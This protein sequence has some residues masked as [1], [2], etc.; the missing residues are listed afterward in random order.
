VL[1]VFW[2][3]I[4]LGGY[5]LIPAEALREAWPSEAFPDRSGPK[6]LTIPE[7]E[8]SP[9][10]LDIV[11]S[12]Y[13]GLAPPNELEALRAQFLCSACHEAIGKAVL[14]PYE[15]QDT[16][17]ETYR[18]A[19]AIVQILKDPRP[20]EYAFGRPLHLSFGVP[21]YDLEYAD[22]ELAMYWII[23]C[24]R[25]EGTPLSNPPIGPWSNN[26]HSVFEE[27]ELRAWL[28]QP[29]IQRLRHILHP[30]KALQFILRS[31]P[32]IPL[33]DTLIE[34]L[35]W[36]FQELGV[37][38]FLNLSDHILS[39]DQVISLVTRFPDIEALS[40]SWNTA[41]K[42]EDIPRIIS[43]IPSLR[44]LH[45][46]HF[47]GPGLF[48]NGNLHDLVLEH[49]ELFHQLESLFCP[50]LLLYHDDEFPFVHA[51]ISFVFAHNTRM[52]RHPPAVVSSVLSTPGQ[53]V[54]ALTDILPLAFQEYNYGESTANTMWR[55]NLDFPLR[56]RSGPNQFSG[57]PFYMTA[58]ML[59]HAAF[60]CGVRKPGEPWSERRIV[61]VP[62]HGMFNYPPHIGQVRGT[63]LFHFDWDHRRMGRPDP[64]RNCW[65]FIY[66]E[67]IRVTV[68][69]EPGSESN[70]PQSA[71]EEQQNS[72][73][74][75]RYDQRKVYDLRG[76]L[77]CM[78]DEGRPLPDNDAVQKLEQI[79]D[80]HDPAT[81]ELICPLVRHDEVGVLLMILV[82]GQMKLDRSRQS[83]MRN[84]FESTPGRKRGTVVAS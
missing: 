31:E 74:K 8:D 78:A 56:I 51:P 50:T 75:I 7:L 82:D 4:D 9:M 32:L 6:Q 28:S 54:Q 5:Q 45:V 38:P 53:V 62:V 68:P 3:L 29:S 61:N 14:P 77:R 81:G 2:S 79:L 57:N 72:G 64:G 55:E 10:P 17:E 69:V 84:M 44:R 41:L 59:A 37:G 11:I 12:L 19:N 80:T 15:L 43:A 76:F 13:L 36:V 73:W 33:M 24:E 25:L 26:P 66:F 52:A 67:M 34:V 40:L 20:F 22:H 60:A 71:E 47:D 42:A 27:S 49:P 65:G 30:I 70:L 21:D 35:A 48:D 39:A 83:A 46:M 16:L 23:E 63:W 18:R 1:S 58:N